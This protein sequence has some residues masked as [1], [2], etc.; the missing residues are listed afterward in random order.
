MDNKEFSNGS[1]DK[2]DDDDQFIIGIKTDRISKALAK[3]N[4]TV[5]H[6]IKP[7][8]FYGYK[9]PAT[10]NIFRIYEGNNPSAFENYNL[11]ELFFHIIPIVD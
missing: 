9:N 7:D 4:I 3:K 10:S 8:I 11:G 5:C 2:G 1:Y 6:F